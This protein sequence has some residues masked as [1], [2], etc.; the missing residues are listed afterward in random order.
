MVNVTEDQVYDALTYEWQSGGKIRN[1]LIEKLGLN[2]LTPVKKAAYLLAFQSWTVSKADFYQRIE[3]LKE[4]GLAEI[5]YRK[6]LEGENLIQVNYV[7]KKR[8]GVREKG[9][10]EIP[11][12]S[13]ETGL[14]GLLST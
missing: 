7:R 6:E 12:L 8:G 11:E 13:I 3:D 4:R 1:D 2:K 14:S 9:A 10:G 5:D